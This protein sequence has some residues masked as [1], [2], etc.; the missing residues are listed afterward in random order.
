MQG[1]RSLGQLQKN[2]ARQRTRS[3]RLRG[4][5]PK[6]GA[7]RQGARADGAMKFDQKM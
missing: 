1:I 3:L 5:I 6:I 4:I 2:D 7:T